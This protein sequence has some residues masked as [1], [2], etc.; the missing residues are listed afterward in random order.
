MKKA[1]VGRWAQG[2]VEDLCRL[3]QM[4]PFIYPHI[5]QGDRSG[6]TPK[7]AEELLKSSPW[8]INISFSFDGKKL[9]KIFRGYLKA[10]RDAVAEDLRAQA[11][12]CDE[13]GAMTV[14]EEK[15]VA[16]FRKKKS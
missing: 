14:N 13:C 15:E 8:P 9:E 1:D 2:M 5:V 16:K 12:Y 10:Y 3:D 6:P 7:T 11:G 4:D